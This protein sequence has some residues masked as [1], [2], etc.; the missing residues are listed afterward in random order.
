MFVQGM[1]ELERKF[2]FVPDFH[3]DLIESILI[4]A[5]RIE[6]VIQTVD[7][8]SR[9]Q[10]WNGTRLKLTFS[11]VTKFQ[12]QGEM[13]GTV[14]IIFDLRFEEKGE[15]VETRIET[16]LGTEGFVLAK[17]VRMEEL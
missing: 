10:K 9:V 15:S 4:T 2:G 8:P 5:N 14:S 6:L 11:D 12:F 17:E 3:D 16:S 1:I 7:G 13:Y